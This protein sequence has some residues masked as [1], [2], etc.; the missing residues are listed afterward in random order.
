MIGLASRCRLCGTPVATLEARR[1]RVGSECWS[2]LTPEQKERALALAAREADP[3]YVPP[4]RRPSAVALANRAAVRAAVQAPAPEAVCARHGGVVGRC[5]QCRR[6]ADPTQAAARIIWEIQQE[7]A[8]A[9]EAAWQARV[10][11]LLAAA[12]G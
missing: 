10:D 11:Q 3:H 5:P 12:D 9:R 6:E 8:A 2:R 7:R 4:A 1:R